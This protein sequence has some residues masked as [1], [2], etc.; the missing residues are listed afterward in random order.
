MLSVLDPVTFTFCMSANPVSDQIGDTETKLTKWA[1]SPMLSA[2]CPCSHPHSGASSSSWNSPPALLRASWSL[3]SLQPQLL[4]LLPADLASGFLRMARAV[5]LLV[6]HSLS[7]C[8]RL[9]V[10]RLQLRTEWL[11]LAHAFKGLLCWGKPGWAELLSL[12]QTRSRERIAHRGWWDGSV[13]KSTWLLYRRSRV[14]IP[15]T[16]WWLTTIRNEIWFPL[17]ECLKTA[18]M[19]F[20]II[21]K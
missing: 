2:H 6:S 8:V 18:T 13:G 7:V 14:Q 16:T 19:Y 12:W 21:N 4:Q 1:R 5:S 9:S 20:H 15:A 17:L 10:W 3:S 11:Y